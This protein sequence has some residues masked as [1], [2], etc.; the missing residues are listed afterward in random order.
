MMKKLL[1]IILGGVTTSINGQKVNFKW[2]INTHNIYNLM[3]NLIFTLF[4]IPSFVY[5]QSQWIQ[6]GQDVDGAV[7]SQLGKEVRMNSSGN[8]IAVSSPGH[9]ISAWGTNGYAVGRVSIYEYNGSS[10]AQKGTDFFGTE[11]YEYLGTGLSINAA[12]NRVAMGTVNGTHAGFGGSGMIKIYSWNGSSWVQM[13]TD[14]YGTAW[15]EYLGTAGIDWGTSSVRKS[16]ISLNATGDRIALGANYS[17]SSTDPGLVRIYSWDGTNWVQLGSDILGEAGS[18][19]F[20]S[21]VSM[22]ALGDRVAIGAPNNNSY[23]GHV[24]VYNWNG[25]SWVQLGND[26]DGENWGDYS[27]TS[28]SMNSAG[29]RVAIGAPENDDN[30]TKSGHTR[31]YSWDGSSWVQFGS[32][33]DGESS[34]DYSGLS[35]S[36]NSAGDR[37]VIGAPFNDGNG[38][39]SGH[40]RIYKWDGSNWTQLGVDI[41]GELLYDESGSSTSIN[42]IGD[43]IASGAPDNGNGSI[44]TGG[45][46]RVYYESCQSP[47]SFDIQTAC[48]SY[49]WIDGNTY[50]S[51][52]STA[53]HIL[54]NILGCDSVVTLNLSITNSSASIDSQITCDSYTWIDGNTYNSNNSTATYSLINSAGCDSIITLNLVVIQPDTSIISIVGCD[55]IFYSGTFFDSNGTYILNHNN[56]NTQIGGDID[57]QYISEQFGYNVAINDVGNILVAGAPF[58]SNNGSLSGLVRVYEWNGL[59]WDQKGLDITGEAAGDKLGISV[60]INDAGTRI[61]LGAQGNDGT[62]SDAGHARVYEW[63]NTNWNQMGTDIDGE[64]DNDKSGSAVS[65]NALGDIVAIGAPYNDGNGIWSG[66]VRTYQWNGSAWVQM[67]ADIDGEATGDNFGFSVSL[68]AFGDKLAVGSIMNDGNGTSAGHVRVYNYNGNNWVQIGVDLD[69]HLNFDHF[70]HSVSLNAAGDKLAVGATGDIFTNSNISGYTGV[71]YYNGIS[72]S[73]IGNEITGDINSD[74]FG[75]SVSL[76][77][78]G[79]RIA[80][81]APDNDYNGNNAGQVKFFKFNGSI[82]NQIGADL[83]GEANGDEFGYSVSINSNGDFVSIGGPTNDGN[84]SNGGHIVVYKPAVTN[85]FGC[86]SSEI[87]TITLLNNLTSTDTQTA[88]DNYTWIDGNTYTASNSTATHTLTNALGCDS[89]VTLNLTVNNSST[90]TDTQTACDSYTWID[91][92]TYTASNST[93]THTLTNALGC[94]SVAT[95]NLIVNN[96]ST[97][98]D[99]QTACDSYTWIDG[100]TYTSS[101]YTATHTLNNAAGC[102]SVVTLNLTINNNAGTDTEISCDSYTWIDGN[103]YTS[104]NNTATHTLTNVAGCDSVVTLN[105]TIINLNVGVI[106]NQNILT[107]SQIGGTYQ[108]VQCPSMSFLPGDTSQVFTATFNSDYAV[109]ITYNGCVDTSACYTVNTVEIIANDFGNE[110]LFYPNPSDGDFTIDLGNTYESITIKLIDLNGKLIETNYYKNTQY[111]HLKIEEPVGIYLLN[112]ETESKKAIIKLIKE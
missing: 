85:S 83:I 45:Q 26:I 78:S 69:G 19:E 90:A 21:S 92:N 39:Y 35:V 98:T 32:D 95:L 72:W 18:D 46:V 94:D 40:T 87:I 25:S 66:T 6:L 53:T 51:N 27:G 10:W 59:L 60:S 84:S 68:N 1:I 110:L 105:L 63:D 31:I 93:A 104:N 58:N 102:D 74:H 24:R 89:V 70:G 61:I 3:K 54:T 47:N 41:D 11:A 12:G 37:V 33:I 28:V 107:S 103:T 7:D 65:M 73:L 22:N 50:T 86:D 79:N 55:S 100:N 8:I 82:W 57:G 49:T 13:G 109:I 75:F 48:D 96:S 108:W 101:N 81:G 99:M 71:Y 23:K 52:N 43:R 29:D 5:S 111:L 42:S 91:G 15:G 64:A 44:G 16:S 97:A 76:N 17:G 106:Q 30:G 34:S 56:F 80:V 88:C 9:D 38:T 112:I 2:S 77:D 20:G 67:G 62:A 36:M 4:L 14:I